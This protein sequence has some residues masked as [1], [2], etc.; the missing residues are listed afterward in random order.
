MPITPKVTVPSEWP[1]PK[2]WRL[3]AILAAC[4]VLPFLLF[5]YAADRFLHRATTNNVLQQT[6]PAA[7]LAANVITERMADGKAALEALAGDSTLLQAWEHND[8]TRLTA[9]LQMAHE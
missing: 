8:I 3:Y 5:L 4:S 1:S 2:R 9:M 6:G 7:E